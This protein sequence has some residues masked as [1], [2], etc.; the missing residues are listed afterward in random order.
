MSYG[1]IEYN[2]DGYL[3][4]EICGQYF[5]RLSNHLR[6]FHVI[7][8]SEYK[9]IYGLNRKQA[10]WSKSAILAQREYL[11]A[12]YAVCVGQNLFSKPNPYRYEKGCKGRTKDLVR[13]QT[14]LMLLNQLSKIDMEKVRELCRELGRSGLGNAKR[15]ELRDLRINHNGR[16]IRFDNEL[17]DALPQ[18]IGWSKKKYGH[19]YDEDITSATILRALEWGKFDFR[20]AKMITWLVGMAIHMYMNK[21]KIKA[22]NRTISLEDVHTEEDVSYQLDFDIYNEGE[23]RVVECIKKLSQREQEVLQM[24]IDGEKVRDIANKYG[25]KPESMKSFLWRA[26]YNLKTELSKISVSINQNE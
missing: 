10:L 12:N 22:R 26:R 19:N 6:F 14:K 1:V 9:E 2:K 23:D 18:L 20:R 13:E 24:V 3:K 7:S 5:N 17:S 21:N 11:F 15:R 16:T 8:S 25:I 4:C